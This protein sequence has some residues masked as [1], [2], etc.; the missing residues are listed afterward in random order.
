M[1]I[2]L[3]LFNQ[4]SGNKSELK[5]LA[6]QGFL[7]GADVAK[8]QI[9]DSKRIWG[10]DSR[11][12]LEMDYF[13]VEEIAEYCDKI[14]I[15]FMATIFNEDHIDWLDKLGI[16]RY[17]IASITSAFKTK[18]PS[19]DKTL[20]N[21]ILSREKETFISLGLMEKNNFPFGKKENVKYLFC[22]AKYPTPL[23]DDELK[24][25][26][27]NFKNEGYFGFSD[28]TLGISAG[29]KSYFYGAKAIEKHFT[30]DNMRQGITEKVTFAHLIQI[31]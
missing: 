16:T 15:G 29:L 2:I 10:D 22:V 24:K 27:K 8:I 14:G 19:G 6:L 23:F 1:E 26:P 20:C 18:S 9:I 28:H 31:P 12:Y 25:M 5:R 11:S 3:D 17:K 21:E 13:D 30:M 7:N 4:H